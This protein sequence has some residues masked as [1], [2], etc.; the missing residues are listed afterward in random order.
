MQNGIE[1]SQTNKMIYFES[2]IYPN[3]PNNNFKK[4]YNILIISSRILN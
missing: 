1:L 3:I 4:F 2:R